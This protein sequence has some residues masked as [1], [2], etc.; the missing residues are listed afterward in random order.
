MAFRRIKDVAVAT[1]TYQDSSGATKNRYANVGVM[2]QGDDGNSF[3]LLDR[4]FNPA[5]VPFKAGGDKVLLSLFEP[6]EESSGDARP[7]RAAAPTRPAAAPTT[8]NDD[9]D[10]PF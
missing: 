1:G 7:A 9:A 4:H 10:I 5:G 2:M 3:I 8:V 6:R